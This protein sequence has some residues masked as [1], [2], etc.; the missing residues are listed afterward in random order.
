MQPR[1]MRA[2]MNREPVGQA[3]TE[4]CAVKVRR[5]FDGLHD[6]QDVVEQM[7]MVRLVLGQRGVSQSVHLALLEREVRR[8]ARLDLAE[9]R[10]DVFRV[11]LGPEERMQRID[12]QSRRQDALT[13]VN[14]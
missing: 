5:R 11:G 12:S 1:V 14:S 3:L 13:C 8:D 9:G 7:F 4:H 10:D 6:V 2:E